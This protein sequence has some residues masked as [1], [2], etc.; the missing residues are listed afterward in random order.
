MNKADSGLHS[1]LA[2][3]FITVLSYAGEDWQI[4]LTAGSIN[5]CVLTHAGTHRNST[6]RICPCNKLPLL[7]IQWA[8]DTPT[9]SACILA[10]S[11]SCVDWIRLLSCIVGYL[12]DVVVCHV[13]N[14]DAEEDLRG[15]AALLLAAS[16][17]LFTALIL[18]QGLC[19]G[20][21]CPEVFKTL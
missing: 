21:K 20:Q 17:W 19:G 18:I 4:P 10:H 8:K 2:C 7:Y 3:S 12:A 11:D 16:R 1:L 9:A 6:Q 5:P 15:A 13:W 14:W